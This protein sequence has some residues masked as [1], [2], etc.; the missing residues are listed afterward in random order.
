M[1]LTGCDTPYRTIYRDAI[2]TVNGVP[3]MHRVTAL[4]AF[5]RVLDEWMAANPD[6]TEIEKAHQI[7]IYNMYVR[8]SD[9]EWRKQRVQ[10]NTHH[11]TGPPD[12]KWKITSKRRLKPGDPEV[13]PDDYSPEDGEIP[14]H[15]I[16]VKVIQ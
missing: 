10:P 2:R 12:T 11:S 6:A 4:R 9:P 5:R 8:Y 1:S 14:T 15:R 7:E 3:V 16:Y 13:P